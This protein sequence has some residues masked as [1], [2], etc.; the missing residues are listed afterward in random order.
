MIPNVSGGRWTAV[1]LASALVSCATP[2]TERESVVEL[3]ARK[4]EQALLVGV[5][6]YEE[7][8]YGEAETQLKSAVAGKLTFP[9]DQVIAYKYLAFVYCGS[10]RQTECSDAFRKALALDPKFQLTP[11]ESGHPIWGPIFKS[12]QAQAQAR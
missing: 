3:A 6:Q 8:N 5:R 11:S 4:P 2:S 7:G 1:L 10:S 9:K 12:A